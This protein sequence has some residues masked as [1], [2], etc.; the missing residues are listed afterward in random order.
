MKYMTE[1]HVRERSEERRIHNIAKRLEG[2]EVVHEEQKNR[3]HIAKSLHL[4]RTST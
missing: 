3:R 1:V 4:M 2:G